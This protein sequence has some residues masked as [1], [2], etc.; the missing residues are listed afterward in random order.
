MPSLDLHETIERYRAAIEHTR[1]EDENFA[2]IYEGFLL[3]QTVFLSFVLTA[4]TAAGNHHHL[5]AAASGLGLL[6]CI[7]WYAA[8]LRNLTKVRFVL[9]RRPWQSHPIGTSSKSLGRNWPRVK[10]DGR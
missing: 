1:F 9:N 4:S 10:G 7:P 3:P 5:L 8:T 6:L 2:R